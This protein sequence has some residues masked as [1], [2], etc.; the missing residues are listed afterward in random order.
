MACNTA[1]RRATA[2]ETVKQRH[3]AGQP[4]DHNIAVMRDVANP[5]QRPEDSCPEL[6]QLR[7]GIPKMFQDLRSNHGLLTMYEFGET[8]GGLDRCYYFGYGKDLYHFDHFMGQFQNE[9]PEL[10][11]LHSYSI[12]GSKYEEDVHKVLVDVV[13]GLDLSHA[14]FVFVLAEKDIGTK[15]GALMTRCLI[16]HK[17]Q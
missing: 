12:E 11:N 2:S 9:L 4:V 7:I 5:V 16:R 13:S 14:Q 17:P 6:H 8:I 3:S 10:V 15:Q 1:Y